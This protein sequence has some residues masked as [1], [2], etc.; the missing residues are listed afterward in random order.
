M[1]L[2]KIIQFDATGNYG[3]IAPDDDGLSVYVHADDLGGCIPGVGTLVRFSTIQGINGPKAYNV[4]TVDSVH[5]R[6]ISVLGEASEVLNPREYAEEI[7]G[8]LIDALPDITA[9]QM[10][11]VRS[12]LVGRAAQHGWLCIDNQ[13]P[14]TALHPEHFVIHDQPAGTPSGIGT[15]HLGTNPSQAGGW[16]QQ[17][18]EEL[19]SQTD[20]YKSQR[21]APHGRSVGFHYVL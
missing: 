8:I 16:T 13:E 20:I 6:E 11:E 10:V 18:T 9:R 12:R 14:P 17:L 15:G 1:R 4:A 2:G 5:S 19:A 21:G 7:A 3:I